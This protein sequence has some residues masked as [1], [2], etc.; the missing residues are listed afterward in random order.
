[1]WY[2]YYSKIFAETAAFSLGALG[3]QK[4]VL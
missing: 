3:A 1:M 4:A 2:H